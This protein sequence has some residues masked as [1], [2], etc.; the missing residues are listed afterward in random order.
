[1]T[2][3]VKY[4]IYTGLITFLWFIIAYFSGIHN[5]PST[6]YVELMSFL[7]LISG[8][9]FSMQQTKLKEKGGF[10]TY[11]EVVRAGVITTFLAA[12]ILATGLYFYYRFINTELINYTLSEAKQYWKN[13]QQ[14]SAFISANLERLKALSTPDKQAYSSFMSA[15]ILGMFFSL[16]SAFFIKNTD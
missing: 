5:S 4:G 2:Q 3:A 12:L 9:L 6:K 14:T 13:Q 11:K 8:I 16:I 1:M 10:I 7:F 15:L